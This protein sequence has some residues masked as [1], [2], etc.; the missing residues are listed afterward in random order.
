MHSM[1]SANRLRRGF[2]EP[3]KPDLAFCHQLGH[4]ANGVFNGDIWVHP[5]L[6]V[7]VNDV[8]SEAAQAGLTRGFDIGWGAICTGDT[9]ISSA[10][11]AE[12]GRE[13]DACPSP[14]ECLT[15]EFFVAPQAI[16]IGRIQEIH[17]QV[18]RAMN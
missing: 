13:D 18:E 1:G 7:Q 15:E 3:E 16:S 9:S 17:A 8:E 14:L 4:R 10:Y 6:I 11:H 2:A 12:F 5:M